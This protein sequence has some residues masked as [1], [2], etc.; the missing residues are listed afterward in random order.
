MF[1]YQK[2]VWFFFS[3]PHLSFGHLSLFVLIILISGVES[4]YEALH[5]AV[6]SIFLTSTIS[7]YSFQLPILKL[8]SLFDPC[9]EWMIKFYTYMKQ[10]AKYNSEYNNLHIFWQHM[11]DKIFWTEWH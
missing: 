2:F 1:S 7:N 4:N 6:F 11:E 3:Q 5:Y 9:L 8:P 10:H